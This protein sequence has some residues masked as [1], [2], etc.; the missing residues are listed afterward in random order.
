[1]DKA[2]G[3]GETRSQQ[4]TMKQS[5]RGSLSPRRQKGSQGRGGGHGGR[6][7]PRTPPCASRRS[8]RLA[9]QEEKIREQT[10]KKEEQATNPF[11]LL[12]MDEEEELEDEEME[13][14]INEMQVASPQW[15]L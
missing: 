2:T 5:E 1:M 6:G 11:A 15:S 4:R 14:K 9:D 12:W 7:T 10:M 13:E 3:R 8:M